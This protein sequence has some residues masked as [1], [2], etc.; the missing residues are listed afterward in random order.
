[1]VWAGVLLLVHLFL[2]GLRLEDCPRLTQ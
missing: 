1:V 2:L